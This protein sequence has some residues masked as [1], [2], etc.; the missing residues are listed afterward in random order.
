MF[1]KD[2]GLI[3]GFKPAKHGRPGGL[4]SPNIEFGNFELHYCKGFTKYPMTV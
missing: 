3:L 1:L 4:K 2:L